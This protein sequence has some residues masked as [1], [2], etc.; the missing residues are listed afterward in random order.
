MIFS[1][2]AWY[3]VRSF[4]RRQ[5]DIIHRRDGYHCKRHL[6]QQVPFVYSGGSVRVTRAT[7]G[8]KVWLRGA[9]VTPG[10]GV[11]ISTAPRTG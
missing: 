9:G 8:E 3:D 6:P 4:I 11:F 7:S 2:A 1:N 10:Q 5:A